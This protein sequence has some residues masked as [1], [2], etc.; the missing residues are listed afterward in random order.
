MAD[1]E[2]KDM[3]CGH[4]V[5]TITKAVQAVDAAA[6]VTADLPARRVGIV[7]SAGTD[8]LKAAIEEAGYDVGEPSAA[9]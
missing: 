1:F 4:C 7:S 6:V 8:R 3:T 2:I 9:R 5:A